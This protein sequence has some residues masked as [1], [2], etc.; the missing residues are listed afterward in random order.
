MLIFNKPRLIN[1][2]RFQQ[3]ISDYGD[4]VFSLVIEA[5][6]PAADS[7]CVGKPGTIQTPDEN[8]EAG[9]EGGCK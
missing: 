1:D 5:R 7:H 6:L 8:T 3:N 9:M 2:K 4:K